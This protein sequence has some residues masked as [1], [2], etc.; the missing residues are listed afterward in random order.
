[1]REYRYIRVDADLILAAD[2]LEH[3]ADGVIALARILEHLDVDD[4]A[5]FRA[6]RLAA[7]NEHLGARLAVKGERADDE[8]ACGVGSAIVESPPAARG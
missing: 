3:A 1:M 5:G 6:A 8:S 2:D 4:V 7:R